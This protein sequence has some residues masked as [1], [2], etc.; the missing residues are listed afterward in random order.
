[1]GA[2][3][4]RVLLPRADHGYSCLGLVRRGIAAADQ[5]ARSA[6]PELAGGISYAPFDEQ[7]RRHMHLSDSERHQ[8]LWN[9]DDRGGACSEISMTCPDRSENRHDG[10]KTA[11]TRAGTPRDRIN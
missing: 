3:K 11:M 2:D 4:A 7:S 8:S 9:H 10:V 5:E 1:M 6:D